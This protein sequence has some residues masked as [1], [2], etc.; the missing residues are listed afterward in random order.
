MASASTNNKRRVSDARLEMPNKTPR[1]EES[2]PELEVVD[3]DGDA[4][5]LVPSEEAGKSKL[6]RVSTKILSLAS[7]AFAA[8]F[9]GRYLEGQALSVEEPPTIEFPEDMS[10][11]FGSLV[12]ILH[13]L[14]E[15]QID[16]PEF[17]ELFL[18]RLLKLAEKY[19]CVHAV[20][21]QVSLWLRETM[22]ETM[23]MPDDQDRPYKFEYLLAALTTSYLIQDVKSFQEISRSLLLTPPKISFVDAAPFNGCE[24]LPSQLWSK[25][26]CAS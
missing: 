20:K 10:E 22:A 8:M 2:V 21:G 17:D 4:L 25:L 11:E 3:P 6:F 15:Q 5:F 9:N 16:A 13:H 1:L 19:D 7:K 14:K 24:M 26:M 18:V 12:R 23:A